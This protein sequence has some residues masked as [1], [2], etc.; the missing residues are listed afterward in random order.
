[1]TDHETANSTNPLHNPH[2]LILSPSKDDLQMRTGWNSSFD[3]L[4]MRMVVLVPKIF[5]GSP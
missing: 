3:G 5:C 4:R 1:M 2:I